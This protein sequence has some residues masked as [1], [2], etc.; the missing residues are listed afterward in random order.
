[1]DER[2]GYI[3]EAESLAPEPRGST[4]PARS[5]AQ[6][7]GP[8]RSLAPGAVRR[9]AVRESFTLPLLFLA[10]TLLASIRVTGAGAGTLGFT[11]PS[12]M[13]LVLGVLF[14]G[15]VVETGL[16]HLPALASDRRSGL[17]N[18]SGVVVLG[19]LLVASAQV[20]ALLT[21][22]RGLFSFV[23]AAYFLFLL[24][25]TL[26]ARPEPPRV[27][28]SLAVTFGGALILKYI[29]LSGLA[30]PGG[31]LAKRLFSTAMEGITLGALGAT[32]LVPAAGYLA[33]TALALFFIG[34][35]LL[36]RRG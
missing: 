21:P 1:M 9:A 27:L 22:D 5:P 19:L 24:L 34:L 25:T 20:F 35:F 36:P 28:R 17:E 30:A 12:L 7:T 18:A 15:L 26:A 4:T 29:V 13:A 23:V 33:F 2:D 10:T 8:A 11:P 3:I 6:P 16:V 14:L 31:S 32:H